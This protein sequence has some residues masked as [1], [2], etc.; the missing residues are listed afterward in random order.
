MTSIFAAN[1]GFSIYL[2][3]IGRQKI[4]NSALKTYGMAIVEFSIQVK[5]DRA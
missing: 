5:L 2:I 4:D 3:G 1:L